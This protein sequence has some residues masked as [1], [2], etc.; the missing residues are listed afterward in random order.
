MPCLATVARAHRLALA[1]LWR[2]ASWRDANAILKVMAG[3]VRL[4]A[5][6]IRYTLAHYSLVT[7]R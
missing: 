5:I 6:R 2:L 7:D 4:A 1:G 3:V